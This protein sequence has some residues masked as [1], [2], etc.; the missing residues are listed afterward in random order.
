VWWRKKSKTKKKRSLRGL[1]GARTRKRNALKGHTKTDVARDRKTGKTIVSSTYLRKKPRKRHGTKKAKQTAKQLSLF[2]VGKASTS[3]KRKSSK[4][5][6][7][8]L[9]TITRKAKSIRRL[10]PNMKWQTAMKQAAKK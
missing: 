6:G 10:H 8:H 1:K 7:S 3:T 5:S 2:G 9:K 4:K